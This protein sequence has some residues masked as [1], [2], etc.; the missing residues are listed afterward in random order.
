MTITSDDPTAVEE[1]RRLCYV[2]IFIQI[3]RNALSNPIHR[4]TAIPDVIVRTTR[5]V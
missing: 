4:P 5:C 1:E 3:T 2:G